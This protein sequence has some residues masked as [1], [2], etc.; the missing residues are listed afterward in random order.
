MTFAQKAL[1]VVGA[2]GVITALTLPGRQTSSVV[3][4]FTNLGTGVL[5][6][7]ETGQR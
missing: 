3:G 7:A 6:T 1:A 5:H 4:S 2:I